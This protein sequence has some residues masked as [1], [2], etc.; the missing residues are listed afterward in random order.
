[1]KVDVVIAYYQLDHEK[2]WSSVLWGLRQNI[3]HISRV[4]VVNDGP[5]RMSKR[6]QPSYGVPI[7]FLEHD[8]DGFGLCKSLNQ[9][10]EATA[11][12]YVLVIEGDEILAPGS[13]EKT[14]GLAQEKVLICANK[15][16]L[17]PEV[18]PVS[19]QP[20]ID[21][22]IEHEHRLKM[23]PQ[24][25]RQWKFCSGGHLL[26]DR[27]AHNQIGGFDTFYE[28]GLHD[29]DYAAR[30]MTVFGDSSVRWTPD[31]GY[32]WH[33][34]SGKGRDF[35]SD[36]AE[37]HFAK[38]L[39]KLY[40]GRYHLACG[41]KHD[42][43]MVNADFGTCFGSDVKVE[44][45]KL[46]WIP[47]DS[48]QV[49]HHSHFLEHM[50]GDTAINHLETCRRKLVDGGQLII[51]CPDMN[52]LCRAY[53]AGEKEVALQ[54]FYS[55]PDKQ[56]KPGW[57]HYSGWDVDTLKRTLEFLGFEI[58][59]AGD[60]YSESCAWRD[61]RVEAIKEDKKNS[62]LDSFIASSEVGTNG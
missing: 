2:Y 18:I 55:D 1:M 23:S 15:E 33:I 50:P 62:D 19:E 12:P 16:Y 57:A 38:A 43:S 14:L 31:A 36:A 8:K 25:G 48:A 59:Y 42:S 24:I 6:A 47:D 28:Y 3:D 41:D 5:Y 11:T 34:G 51:E 52:K 35:P 9:G 32:V 54:G 4:F 10:I 29:F 58:D 40:G 60:S 20:S 21:A 30:W 13:L 44:C 56:T 39:G 46:D 49:I 17:D 61:L 45:I 53:L 7:S 27:K 22:F 26:I 37:V